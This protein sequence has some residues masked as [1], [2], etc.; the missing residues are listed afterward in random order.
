MDVIGAQ[1]EKK[2]RVQVSSLFQQ[3]SSFMEALQILSTIILGDSITLGGG[4]LQIC[5]WSPN[6]NKTTVNVS[7]YVCVDS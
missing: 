2:A 3:D 5:D 1:N 4:S 7:F 6:G